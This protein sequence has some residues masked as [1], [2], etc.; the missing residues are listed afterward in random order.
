MNVTGY[1]RVSTTEQGDS[2]NG[3]EAQA[4]AIRTFCD[5]HGLNLLAIHEEV[6]SGKY[7]VEF[8]PVLAQAIQEAEKARGILLVSKIDRLSRNMRVLTRLMDSKKYRVGTVEDGLDAE[9]VM[10]HI[11]GTFSEFERDR[12]SKRTKEALATV[13]ARG[14][15]LGGFRSEEHRVKAL[16]NSAAAVKADADTFAARMKANVLRMRKA[17]MTVNQIADELNQTNVPT[18]RGGS[19][20]ASSVCNLLRRLEGE[21]VRLGK[22][23]N[24]QK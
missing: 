14:T 11:K 2:R 15:V 10:L 1:I 22:S 4:A 6:V 5:I 8:R 17:G 16:A 9:K 7:D 24:S 21:V 23:E 12:I 18:P 13:K 19:W 20:Y 3:L